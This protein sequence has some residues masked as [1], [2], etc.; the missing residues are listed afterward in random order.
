MITK[1]EA[2]AAFGTAA[3]LARALDISP[4]AVNQWPNYGPIPKAQEL[5]LRYELAPD[6]FPSPAAEAAER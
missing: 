4:P 5:R 3:N 1:E 6:R 2:I